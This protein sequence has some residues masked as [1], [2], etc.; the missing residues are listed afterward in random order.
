MCITIDDKIRSNRAKR[1]EGGKR[2]MQRRE[3]GHGGG[4]RDQEER[5]STTDLLDSLGIYRSLRNSVRVSNLTPESHN[6]LTAQHGVDVV[7]RHVDLL[8]DFGTRQDDLAR[9]ED[10]QDHLGLDHAVDETREE[11]VESAV[12]VSQD[13]AS[14]Q[15][16]TRQKRQQER[17]VQTHQRAR[18]LIPWPRSK[19]QQTADSRGT[20]WRR[21]H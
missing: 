9:N 7:E 21:R 15:L 10:E 11:L 13:G 1:R 16:A 17:T 14:A 12:F 2:A 3:A 18:A 4:K 5:T 20:K 19:G 8:A 6:R